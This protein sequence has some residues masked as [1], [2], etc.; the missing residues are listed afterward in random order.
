MTRPLDRTDFAILDAL[1]NDARLSNKELAAR[2]HLAPSSCLERVRKLREDGVLRG[3]HADVDPAALGIGLEA[4]IAVRMD[5][6]IRET[7]HAFLREVSELPE[8]VAVYYLAGAIDYLVHVAVRDVAHL[9]DF[10]VDS[11]TPRHGVKH[12]ETQIVFEHR[13]RA[14]RPAWNDRAASGPGGS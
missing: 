11:I 1:Q 13:R 7:V 12:V 4:M 10:A 9:R 5:V 6:H 8:V 14:A 2:V 3:F